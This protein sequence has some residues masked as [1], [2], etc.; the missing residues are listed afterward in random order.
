MA[1]AAG[2]FQTPRGVTDG[3]PEEEPRRIPAG[4]QSRA[5]ILSRLRVACSRVIV[6]DDTS[7]T[8]ASQY[9]SSKKCFHHMDPVD[10]GALP[11]RSW[12]C[13]MFDPAP[14]HAPSL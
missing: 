4:E 6:N 14:G 5:A 12:T 13:V 3:A 8:E 10:P 7:V 2:A 9:I 11:L 1:L